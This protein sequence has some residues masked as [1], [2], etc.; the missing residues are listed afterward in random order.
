M[1]PSR[2]AARKRRVAPP[3]PFGTARNCVGSPGRCAKLPQQQE[4]SGIGA[5]RKP[6]EDA[7]TNA[8][9]CDGRKPSREARHGKAQHQRQGPRRAGRGR[10]AAALGHPRAGRPDRHEIRLRRRAMR[11]LLGAHQRRGDALL[12][13]PG[14]Q[15]QGRRQDRHHRRPVGQ[16]VASG[17][18]GL[19][20]GRRA[21]VRLLPV[22]PDHGGGGAA[23][24]KSAARPTRTSTKR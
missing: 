21:A 7:R 9:Q 3:P 22:R 19:G 18:E 24:E 23:E 12:L 5:G 10:H 20:G 1:P 17:A 6:A 13:D 16:H 11:R 2:H 14:R 4:Q 15:R 8:R